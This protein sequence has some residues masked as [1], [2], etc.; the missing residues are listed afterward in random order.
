[1]VCYYGSWGV[2]RPGA[3]HISVNEIDAS[4][5]THL[6]YSFAGLDIIQ[7][8]IVP[9]DPNNDLSPANNNSYAQFI[10]L[11]EQNPCLK[12]VI[13]LGGWNEMSRKYS[14][15]SMIG[16]CE[17]C[18]PHQM[19]FILKMASDSESVKGF[20]DNALRFITQ[21]QFDGLDFDW[22]Y[23]SSRG[24]I[25][26]DKDN[27]LQVLKALKE[28]FKPWGYLLTVAVAAIENIAKD[29]YNIKELS[30]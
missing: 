5:C 14:V 25:T 1:M 29:A 27:F 9:L 3:G 30:Q 7:N 19:L 10:A 8:G 15:V 28:K 13:A 6:V 20:A 11:K 22:E 26:A 21:H 2:Y 24:G 4:L 17:V 12:I 18:P 16:R 23:P